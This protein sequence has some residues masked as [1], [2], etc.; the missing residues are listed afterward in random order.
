MSARERTSTM[1]ALAYR[2]GQLQFLKDEP[3]PELQPG[4]ALLKIR[5]AGLCNTDMELVRGYMGFSGILGHEFVAEVVQGSPEWVGKRVVGEINVAC[6][7]CDMC[8]RDIPSQCRHRTTVGIDR[9]PGAF[10]DYLALDERRLH[11]VPDTISDDAAVFV[12]PLAAA[13][14]VLEA[15]HILPGD[16]VVLVGAG[17]LGLLISQVLVSTGAN[18]T[19]VSRR[20][21]TQQ[22]LQHWGIPFVA[23][24]D[25]PLAQADVVIES[26]GT[27]E[28]FVGAMNLLRPRGTMIMKST[29]VGLTPADLTKAV[30]DEIRLVGSRCGPFDSA[31]R[32]LANGRIDTQSLIDARY[33]FAR[34]LKAF[35][36]AQKPSMLKV[37]L[38][39]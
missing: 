12:E 7:T 22:L 31:I 15:T 8:R 9:H 11:V 39:F 29:F 27:P 28:G 16:R 10:A 6:G 20:E 26:T 37:I 38:D 14:H 17:K 3:V 5:Q 1:R 30:I 21:K 24:E 2:K 25:L 18:L 34:A 36:Q 13:L 4:Q 19:V 23:L 35:E 32:L 33:P